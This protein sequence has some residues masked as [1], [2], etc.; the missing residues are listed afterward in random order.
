MHEYIIQ[1]Y[2]DHFNWITG[3]SGSGK[4][5][6]AEKL[7][8]EL[9]NR[10]FVNKGTRK[11]CTPEPASFKQAKCQTPFSGHQ[12]NPAGRRRSRKGL[13]RKV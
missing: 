12:H 9:K 11:D 6:I 7:F 5:T 1:H 3:L 8:E 4:S 2:V 10:G 13:T